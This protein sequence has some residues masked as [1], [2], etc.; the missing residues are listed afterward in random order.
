M[1]LSLQRGLLSRFIYGFVA[2]S[3]PREGALAALKSMLVPTQGTPWADVD[4]WVTVTRSRVVGLGIALSS[5]PYPLESARVAVVGERAAIVDGRFFDETLLTDA[6][7]PLAAEHVLA[8]FRSRGQAGLASLRGEATCAV[9]DGDREALVVWRDPAGVR[10]MYT[11]TDPGSGLFA[12]ASDLECIAAVP[13]FQKRLDLQQ[14][15]T[16]LAWRDYS[17][18][19][20]TLLQD[21]ERLP[22]GSMLRVVNGDLRVQ[23]YWPVGSSRAAAISDTGL[24]DDVALLRQRVQTAVEERIDSVDPLG[25][26]LTGGLDS[27]SIAVLAARALQPSRPLHTFS[28]APPRDELEAQ[29]MDERDL[30]DLVTDREP[31]RHLYTVIDVDDLTYHSTADLTTRPVITLQAELQAQRNAAAEGVGTILSGW[32]GDETVAFNGRGY[33][34]EL[35]RRGRFVTMQ[36]ELKQRQ[37]AFDIQWLGGWE[38]R[39][40]LPNVPD[41]LFRAFFTAYAQGPAPLPPELRPDF[42]RELS[43]YRPDTPAP[44]RELPGASRMQQALFERGHLHYRMEAWAAHDER[45]GV[46]YS[47]PLL[48]AKVI[49]TAWRLQPA[50]YFHRGWKRWGYRSAMEGVLADD[51]RWLAVKFDSAYQRH[52]QERFPRSWPAASARLRT[53]RDNPYV[54]IAALLEPT[55]A[56]RSVSSHG[57]AAWLAFVK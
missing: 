53:R 29:T 50:I 30:V 15:R 48:D 42:A 21:V 51:L 10:P 25:A 8:V 43:A 3:L 16:R 22:P 34:A 45:Q 54:D 27:S 46:R 55:E 52:L 31:V 1:Y 35:A 40:L 57:D 56:H 19:G 32:G 5:R 11:W 14:V 6:V 44:L 33:L 28:W 49:E 23:R 13:D 24:A 20:R 47:F 2:P 41:P 17:T 36:R 4:H 18:P 12:F 26:H 9:W 39:V 7:T 38:G 37:D